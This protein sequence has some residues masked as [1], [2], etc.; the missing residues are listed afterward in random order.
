MTGEPL[1]VLYDGDCRFCRA[2]IT[3]AR[4]WARPPGLRCLPFDDPRAVALLSAL[5][6]GERHAAFHVVEG[7][8]LY[9][10]TGAFMHLLR[11]LPGGR[12][13]CA[14]GAYRLY[15]WIVRHRTRL[16]RLLPDT[17]RP[18]EHPRRPD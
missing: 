4:R 8:R 18:P 5:P 11:Q 9:S 3:R 1:I 7:H 6:P 10:A 14:L 16:G 15:P 17:P 12:A 2:S 13:A